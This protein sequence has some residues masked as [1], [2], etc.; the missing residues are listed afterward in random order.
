MRPRAVRIRKPCWIRNGSTTS[1]SVP[2]SSPTRGGEALDAHRAAVEL[3][4]DRRAAACGPARRSPAD[5]LRACRAPR[6]PRASS[7]RPSAFTSAKSRTRRSRRL[8]MRGV[9]RERCAML[10]RAV[11]VDGH[12][13]DAGRAR[14]D[15]LE[16]GRGVELQPLHDAEAVAQRRGQQA[17]ARGRA[18]QRERRQVELDR[19]RR[20][21]LRRS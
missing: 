21:A 13:E 8:A 10:R 12:A 16:L 3:L 7:M 18:D 2:R 1:S 6:A 11:R 5:P 20:R 17:R 14:H 15:A 9:P 4:D 19:A